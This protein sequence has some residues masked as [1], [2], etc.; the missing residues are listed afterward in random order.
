VFEWGGWPI[1][2]VDAQGMV[3]SNADFFRMKVVSS[4]GAAFSDVSGPPLTD[5]VTAPQTPLARFFGL[6]WRG[7]DDSTYA[8]AETLDTEG[9]HYP[10]VQDHEG[11]VYAAFGSDA[12]DGKYGVKGTSLSPGLRILCSDL[13]FRLL[14]CIVRGT[15]TG[16]ERT[17]N[18]RGS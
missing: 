7:V 12:S 10:S 3:F 16:A 17:S 14:G 8:V 2:L 5:S 1:G 11:V 18:P 15:I 13:E 9:N 4:L 6:V